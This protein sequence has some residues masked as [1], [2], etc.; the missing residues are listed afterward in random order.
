MQP[1][2]LKVV[3]SNAEPLFSYQRKLISQVFGC[4]VRETYGMSEMVAAAGECEHGRLHLWPEAGIVEVLADDRDEP[5]PN[6]EVGRLICTGLINEDMPLIRYE[7]G[8]RGSWRIPRRVVL[9]AGRC[10]SCNR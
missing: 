9:A 4:P 8:D 6:G 3:I 5:L 1:P 2:G 7:L 10:P